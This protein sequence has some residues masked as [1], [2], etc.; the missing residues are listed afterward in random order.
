MITRTVFTLALLASLAACNSSSTSTSGGGDQTKAKTPSDG[1]LA[2]DV[3][4]AITDCGAD[5]VMKIGPSQP[6]LVLVD[7][8]DKNIAN[9]GQPGNDKFNCVFQAAIAMKDTLAVWNQK[10]IVVNRGKLP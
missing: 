6:R 1:T 4:A 2:G 3:K 10:N 7:L 8:I 5:A 9:E